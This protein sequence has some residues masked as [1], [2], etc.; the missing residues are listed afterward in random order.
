MKEKARQSIGKREVTSL[1]NKFA[2]E[3]LPLKSI[4]EVKDL[5]EKLVP[6]AKEIESS[7]L[8]SRYSN[9]FSVWFIIPREYTGKHTLSEYKKAVDDFN[10]LLSSGESI[11]IDISREDGEYYIKAYS[12]FKY[13]TPWGDENYGDLEIKNEVIKIPLDNRKSE[14][15]NL[16]KD[17]VGLSSGTI[18]KLISEENIGEASS[19]YVLIDEVQKR[20]VEFTSNYIESTSII[21]IDWSDAW[22]KFKRDNSI[23]EIAYSLGLDD[24][25]VKPNYKE[26]LDANNKLLELKQE[27]SDLLNLDNVNLDT[28]DTDSKVKLTHAYSLSVLKNKCDKDEKEYINKISLETIPKVLNGEFEKDFYDEY[29]KCG[30]EILKSV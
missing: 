23:S 9:E 1:I 14:I 19:L 27:L 20:F 6:D 15:D 4:N 25:K 29:S 7:L 30:L 28:L 10:S 22:Y 21:P 11:S 5:V 8:D 24:S 12:F 16:I 2:K 3:L 17:I 18:S 13:D 26:W